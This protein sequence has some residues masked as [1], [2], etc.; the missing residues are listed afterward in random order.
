ML[1]AVTELY[2]GLHHI[3]TA[4]NYFTLC[5]TH[6]V[7]QC[8][9]IRILAMV[10]MVVTLTS[11]SFTHCL[12]IS[13]TSIALPTF[14]LRRPGSSVG[15]ATGYRLDGPGIKSWWGQ[16]FPPV[17]TGPGAHSVSCTMGAGSF[18]GLKCD[19]GR[20]LTT[21]PLLASRSWKNRAIPLHTSRPQPGL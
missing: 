4:V 17:Q 13:R 11:K 19:Q 15:I 18:P 7:L 12:T 6:A 10:K 20:L 2:F 5:N 3:S 1:S 21:H 9:C 14:F 16:D 8:Y